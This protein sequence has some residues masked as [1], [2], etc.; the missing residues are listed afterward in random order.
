MGGIDAHLWTYRCLEKLLQC[1]RLENAIPIYQAV[2]QTWGTAIIA[3]SDAYL[4]NR[5]NP[6]DGIAVPA[7]TV[8]ATHQK[9]RSGPGSLPENE[10]EG[11]SD[12]QFEACAETRP[13]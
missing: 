10:F 13:R 9:L 4:S 5:L 3:D 2:T 1:N 8:D 11:P 6:A 12:L 7:T